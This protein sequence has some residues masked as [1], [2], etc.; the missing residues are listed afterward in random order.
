MRYINSRFTY[1]LTYLCVW[2]KWM[3][4]WMKLPD[5]MPLQWL[6][7]LA[8]TAVRP[9][10]RPRACRV[11]RPRLESTR[12]CSTATTARTCPSAPEPGS[13][14]WNSHS[15]DSC[16][17]R[18]RPPASWYQPTDHPTRTHTHTHIITILSCGGW[19]HCETVFDVM[20]LVAQ[21]G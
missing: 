4:E 6:Y 11:P 8:L 1:L 14:G 7:N 3:N 17:S 12:W 18:S 15:A 16:R 20:S 19:P 21:R 13:T 9:A 2:N 5:N 10:W